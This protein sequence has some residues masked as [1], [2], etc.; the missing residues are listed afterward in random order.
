MQAE[1]AANNVSINLAFLSKP[2]FFHA[3]LSAEQG[4]DRDASR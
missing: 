4:S 2:V 1:A 3:S